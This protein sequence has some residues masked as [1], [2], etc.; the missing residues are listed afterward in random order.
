MTYTDNS[1]TLTE[2]PAPSSDAVIEYGDAHATFGD[3]LTAA[4][5]AFGLSP[6]QLAWRLG[7][8]RATI[9]SWEND[10]SEPRSNRMQML[11]GVLNVSLIWLM[12]G[13][14]DG[15]G[16]APAAPAT[17]EAVGVLAEFAALRVEQRRLADRFV[18]LEARLRAALI[19]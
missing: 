2:N 10:Q 6:E 8:R 15:P 17:P 16:A 1:E 3:R 4:R 18:R 11:A 12:T 7:V 14:G 19:G 9:F 13:E 5:E